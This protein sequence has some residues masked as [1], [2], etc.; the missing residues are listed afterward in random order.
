MY[1]ML[2]CLDTKHC[3]CAK[4]EM[5]VYK[6]YNNRA[7]KSCRTLQNKVRINVLPE[8]LTLFVNVF[9]AFKNC[10]VYKFYTI[11]S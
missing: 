4:Y 10:V 9:M 5:T 3:N 6:S 11:T 7:C 8:Q 1:E 2:H